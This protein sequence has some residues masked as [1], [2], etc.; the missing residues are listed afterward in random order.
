[1]GQLFSITSHF[2][3]GSPN[4]RQHQNKAKCNA[5]V[6]SPADKTN[7]YRADQK[8]NHSKRVEYGQA[9]AIAITRYSCRAAVKNGR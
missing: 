3:Q 6:K 4:S 7:D 2:C 5:E 9:L 8:T 1:M